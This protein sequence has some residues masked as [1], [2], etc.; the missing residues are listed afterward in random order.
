MPFG[1]PVKVVSS[2]NGPLGS[3]VAVVARA[4]GAVGAGV[5]APSLAGRSDPGGPGD[6]P[7]DMVSGSADSSAV[8][9]GRNRTAG[10]PGRRRRRQ[11]A[12]PAGSLWT[13]PR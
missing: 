10:D 2:P 13:G 8:P 7:R 11:S 4:P 9:S 3:A 1:F 5:A 6:R 12:A